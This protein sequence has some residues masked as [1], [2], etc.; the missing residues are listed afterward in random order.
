[1]ANG[2]L[3]GY[4]IVSTTTAYSGN[5]QSGQYSTTNIRTFYGTFRN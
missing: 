4:N 3:D 5:G 1:M 2:R